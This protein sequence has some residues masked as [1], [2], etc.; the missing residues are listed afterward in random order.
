MQPS[1]RDRRHAGRAAA[2]RALPWC[3]RAAAMT[4]AAARAADAAGW[5]AGEADGAAWR[6]TAGGRWTLDEVLKLE[7]ARRALLRAAPAAGGTVHLTLG[8]LSAL[9]TAGAWQLHRLE[10]ELQAAGWRVEAAEAA[11]AHAGLLA[12]IRRLGA[13]PP[14][15]PAAAGALVQ[16]LARIGRA[17]IEAGLEAARLTAFFGETVLALGRVLLRPRRLRLTSLA[18]HLEQT[19]LNALP[20]VG[21]IAFL[22]GV[23]MAYQGADQLRRF[24][25]EIFTVDL[26]GLAIM[27][28]IGGL[29]TAIVV[30][31]RSGSAFTAAIGAMAV[32][33]EIDALRTLGLDPIEALV[34]PRLLALMIALP[35]LTFFAIV[36]GLVG[37]GVMALVALDLS[38]GQFVAQLKSAVAPVH[39]WIGMVKAPVFAFMI[40]LV[41]C[42]EGMNVT[43]S[44]ESVGRLT[45]QSVVVGIFLVIVVDALFSILFSSLGL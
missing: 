40:A 23:V 21:L 26:L 5:L 18:F 6:I 2:A 43:G 7:Q 11:P 33:E 13:A 10:Q 20:I 28:E 14:A 12:E 36:M 9:D 32:N 35:L 31:G 37:G 24:G 8:A 1:R 30:A 16:L 3:G 42:Y 22:I 44:A 41:G 39:F 25:A 17:A 4:G 27:R 15:P 19:C 29:I 45:T 38:P 34:L